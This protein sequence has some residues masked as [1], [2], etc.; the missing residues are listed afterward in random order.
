VTLRARPD[1]TWPDQAKQNT[2]A[3]LDS[4]KKK[5]REKKMRATENEKFNS[6]S[7]RSIPFVFEQ[8]VIFNPKVKMQ[9]VEGFSA[10]VGL[11][12]SASLLCPC[13]QT[14]DAWTWPATGTRL[15][16]RSTQLKT[17]QRAWLPARMHKDTNVLNR[18]G[19]M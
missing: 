14:L 16:S 15:S 13:K 5:M 9:S 18:T 7:I 3:R 2:E 11:Y 4:Q 19:R 1:L 8:R 12:S 17:G 10:T 6:P